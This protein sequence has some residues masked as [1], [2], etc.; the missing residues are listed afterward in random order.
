M[1]VTGLSRAGVITWV[2]SHT[3]RLPSEFFR[4]AGEA[5]ANP[6]A[7]GVSYRN[8]S[9]QSVVGHYL[10]DQMGPIRSELNSRGG[11]APRRAARDHLQ[12]GFSG[13]SA[14]LERQVS[15]LVREQ[16]GKGRS[17]V[18][19]SEPGGCTLGLGSV[20]SPISSTRIASSLRARFVPAATISNYL[21]S[22]APKCSRHD[23]TVRSAVQETAQ[24]CVEVTGRLLD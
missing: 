19:Q 1:R 13:R 11:S 6:R 20:G 21:P 18:F 24:A 8:Q 15:A 4:P 5:S 12:L 16:V 14:A 7:G 23:F 22:R 9:K 2:R 3:K 17:S 10:L